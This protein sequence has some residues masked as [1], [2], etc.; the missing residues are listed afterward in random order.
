MEWMNTLF[1]QYGYGLL[2]FGLFLES[3]ALPFPGELAMALSG[4]SAYA[5]TSS[6]ALDLLFSFAGATIGTTITYALGRKLGRPFFEKYGKYVFLKPDRIDKLADWFGKYGNKLLLVSYYIPGLRHF[7][8]Y[9]SGILN[10]RFGS[11]L[12]YNHT[13]A[14]LW[15]VTYVM[16]GRLFGQ[17]LEYVLHLI[18]VYSWRAAV[19][20]A[21]IIG[22]AILLKRYRAAFSRK[23]QSPVASR[24]R[25]GI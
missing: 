17:Q 22:L 21:A 13:G 20:I 19:V 2:F 24:D 5:G 18:T 8:G 11:F 9:M 7:T 4:Y 3:L 16:V 10:V 15:V 25:A 14:L 12:L 1:E 6:L 23:K